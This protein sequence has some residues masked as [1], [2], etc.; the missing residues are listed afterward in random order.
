ML[1]KNVKKLTEPGQFRKM[2]SA[3]SAR[4]YGESSEKLR[5]SEHFWKMRPTKSEQDCSESS[6]CSWSG[7]D[8][9]RQRH[10]GVGRFSATLVTKNALARLR[11]GK[12]NSCCDTPGKPGRQKVSRTVVRAQFAVG[13][14]GTPSPAPRGRW[15][16]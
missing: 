2:R 9:H 1:F 10:A 5:V 12:Y 13:L 14:V 15:S 3:K 11:A 8:P 7:R 6:I 16:I 4:D